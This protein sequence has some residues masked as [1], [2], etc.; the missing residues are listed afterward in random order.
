[1]PTGALARGSPP[2]LSWQLAAAVPTARRGWGGAE[3]GTCHRAQSS[4]MNCLPRAGSL[5]P[6]HCSPVAR[7][8]RCRAGSHAWDRRC[9]GCEGVALCS[10]LTH[11]MPA[12]CCSRGAARH[13]RHSSRIARCTARGCRDGRARQRALGGR[14]AHP[15]GERA[16][17]RAS[18]CLFFKHPSI[19]SVMRTLPHSSAASYRED[20]LGSAEHAPRSHCTVAP[21]V[22]AQPR[23]RRAAPRAQIKRAIRAILDEC[24]EVRASVSLA[25]L[26]AGYSGARAATEGRVQGGEG[27]LGEVLDGVLHA[28]GAARERAV[29]VGPAGG[30][31]GG[32]LGGYICTG[33]VTTPQKYRGAPQ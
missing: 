21:W 5:R 26:C 7:A 13:A 3:R 20:A 25:P 23:A 17:S 14:A 2:S 29:V 9:P 1:M 4:S 12:P 28:L 18:S 27:L 15:A 8:C 24:L 33:G 30:P 19:K 22:L 31:H 16:I 10:R 32:H 11:R 6:R